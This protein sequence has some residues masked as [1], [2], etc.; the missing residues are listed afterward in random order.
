MK[1]V[2]IKFLRDVARF[3]EGEVKTLPRSIAHDLI[4]E[5]RAEEVTEEVSEEKPKTGRKKK[6]EEETEE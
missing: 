1:E 2:N 6:S 5:K 4:R 3:K